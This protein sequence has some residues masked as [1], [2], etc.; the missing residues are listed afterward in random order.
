[1]FLQNLASPKDLAVD[2][3]CYRVLGVGLILLLAASMYLLRRKPPQFTNAVSSHAWSRACG[4]LRHLSSHI[5]YNAATWSF[6]KGAGI[7]VLLHLMA[8]EGQPTISPHVSPE[9]VAQHRTAQHIL[10]YRC[11]ISRGPH[12]HP[13]LVQQFSLGQESCLA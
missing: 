3:P 2:E 9:E 13:E 7:F 4:W 1:M 5:S 12:L 6:S 11:S 8:S 10:W